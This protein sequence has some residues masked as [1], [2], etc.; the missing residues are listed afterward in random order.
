VSLSW[1][2]PNGFIDDELLKVIRRTAGTLRWMIRLHPNQL[3]GFS[4]HEGPKFMKFYEQKLK[5]APGLFR[6]FDKIGDPNKPDSLWCDNPLG[7]RFATTIQED[8]NFDNWVRDMEMN[9][10]SRS[11]QY[12]CHAMLLWRAAAGFDPEQRGRWDTR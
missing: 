9:H 2:Q 6:R 11:V 3:K 10:G 1:G 4:S 8:L 7:Y 5:G 12:V